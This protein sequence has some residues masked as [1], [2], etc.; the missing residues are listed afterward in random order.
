[1]EQRVR[2]VSWSALIVATVAV[3]IGLIAVVIGEEDS[4]RFDAVVAEDRADDDFESDLGERGES[5]GDVFGTVD[6]LERDGEESGTQLSLCT[7][8]GSEEEPRALCSTT[9]DFA[10][11]SIVAEGILDL[12]LK[13]ETYELAILGG[14]GDYDG[15]RGTVT[16]EPH[17]EGE[18]LLSVDAKTED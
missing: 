8:E 4:Q 18:T 6:P 13:D 14:T 9:L 17:L 2:V 1:M 10:E 3:L 16:V 12:V 15:A 7:I 11:G 5:A